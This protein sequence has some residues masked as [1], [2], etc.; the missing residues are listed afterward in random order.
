M[1]SFYANSNKKSNLYLICSD[2]YKTSLLPFSL[3]SFKLCSYPNTLLFVLIYG[4]YA[5]QL[6]LSVEMR[7]ETSKP[8]DHKV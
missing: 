8:A 6:Y 2:V 1:R 7:L 4:S 5:E 3:K